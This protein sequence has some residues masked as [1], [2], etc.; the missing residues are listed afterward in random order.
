MHML[1]LTRQVGERIVMTL[2]D[3]RTITILMA[4]LKPGSARIGIDAP[5]T[6]GVDR[7]E[8][9]VRKQREREERNGNG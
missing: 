5:V 7:E 6:I 1:M 4:A 2:E 9:Y 3:G 8:I